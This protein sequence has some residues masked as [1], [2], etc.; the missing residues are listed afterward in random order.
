MNSGEMLFD[1]LDYD[2]G[3][4]EAIRELKSGY[5]AG[6][7][8]RI[9]E[10]MDKSKSYRITVPSTEPVKKRIFHDV[11]RSILITNLLSE[12]F[13]GPSMPIKVF[14]SLEDVKGDT[15]LLCEDYVNFFSTQFLSHSKHGK[16]VELFQHIIECLIRENRVDIG[17]AFEL[18]D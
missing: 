3:V 7:F 18:L 1:S 13:N 8:N 12:L 14:D 5:N 15:M 2:P 17:K 6:G 9:Y 16:C 10:I 4:V 11:V